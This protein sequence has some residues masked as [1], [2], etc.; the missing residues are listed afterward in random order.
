MGLHV[1]TCSSSDA[2]FHAFIPFRSRC[3]RQYPDTNARRLGFAGLRQSKGPMLFSMSSHQKQHARMQATS[4]EQNTDVSVAMP[5]QGWKQK[6][7]KHLLIMF[8]LGAT[9]GPAV[10]GIHGQVH[11]VK[12]SK[13]I[14]TSRSLLSIWSMAPA[15][16]SYCCFLAC[17]VQALCPVFKIGNAARLRPASFI[18]RCW[19]HMLKQILQSASSSITQLCRVVY[20][21]CCS[22]SFPSLPF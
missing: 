12:P 3:G 7:P 16:V 5:V 4:T 6:A 13:L 20:F 17:R 11:L 14:C 10:D 1:I 19:A 9:I 22:L 18:S 8:F 21:P 15:V 2:E